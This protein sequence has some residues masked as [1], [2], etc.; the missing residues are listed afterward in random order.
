MNQKDRLEHY[1]NKAQEYF[2]YSEALEQRIK[3]LNDTLRTIS[4]GA[5]SS[6]APSQWDHEYKTKWTAAEALRTQAN[7][8]SLKKPKGYLH[9]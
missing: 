6:A 8:F 2:H 5:V 1:K 3:N 9:P 4:V 7:D